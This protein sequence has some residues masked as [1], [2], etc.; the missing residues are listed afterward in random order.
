MKRSMQWKIRELA[1]E[2]THDLRRAVSADGRTDLPSMHH[3]LD[4]APGTW[5]LGAVAAAG[6]I[7]AIS[8]FYFEAY[9]PRPEAQPAVQLAFMAVDPAVQGKGIGTAVMI[10][11]I[12]RLRAGEAVLLWANARDSA[13]P[14][15]ERFGFRTV[16][17]SEYTLPQSS[18]PHHLIEL[19]LT[20][21]P[22][23][24]REAPRLSL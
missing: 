10:E 3:D 23:L 4:D 15:Y 9:P 8:S 22:G 19:D 14:F 11:A 12:R 24:R 5:H 13:L 16:P 17:A 7:V 2:E 20:Q 6:R 1:A 18:R 21:R